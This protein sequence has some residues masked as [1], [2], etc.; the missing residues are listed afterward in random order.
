[1]EKSRSDDELI[2]M[3]RRGGGRAFTAMGCIINDKTDYPGGVDDVFALLSDNE[4]VSFG[5]SPSH[6]AQAYLIHKGLIRRSDAVECWQV[7]ELLKY[8]GV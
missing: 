2:E 5:Y 3:V 8:Y 7:E 4:P 6:L 1:M